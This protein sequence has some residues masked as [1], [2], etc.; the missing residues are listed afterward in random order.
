MSD[1]YQ[2]ETFFRPPEVSR[3]PWKLAGQIFN[4]CR[5]L[6][7]RS[8]GRAVFVPIRSMQYLAV[9]DDEEIIF[10]DSQ[11][12]Y[13]YLAGA[14]GRPILE[15]WQPRG[16]GARSSLDEAVPCDVV[17][18]RKDLDQ[19]HLRLV[20]EFAK[21]SSQLEQQYRDR[22]IPSQGAKIIKVA[23]NDRT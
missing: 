14:G 18:Y 16:V 17:H 15:S 22:K 21:A 19:L 7:N 10:V 11:G 9:I 23:V 4:R 1:G 2:T 13:G 12:G 8:P 20:G 3:R 5:L 6:L